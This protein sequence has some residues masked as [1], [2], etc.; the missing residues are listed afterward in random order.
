MCS[1]L[2]VLSYCLA[3]ITHSNKKKWK[4]LLHRTW[5]KQTHT[6]TAPNTW[7]EDDNNVTK[8]QHAHKTTKKLENKQSKRTS[9]PI[10]IRFPTLC[11]IAQW[12]V[13]H[14]KWLL[15]IRNDMNEQQQQEVQSPSQKSNNKQSNHNSSQPMK[16][17]WN[18]TH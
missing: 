6:H 5:K 13:E 14:I 7:I 18:D 9:L 1:H 10:L 16:F 2:L 11:E 4:N 8:I 3:Y 12:N 17:H 15:R